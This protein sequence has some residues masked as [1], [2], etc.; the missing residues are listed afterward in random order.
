MIPSSPNERLAAVARDLSRECARRRPQL[1]KV[2]CKQALS[3]GLF[4][5]AS[6]GDRPKL[7]LV[8]SGGARAGDAAA[9]M[10]C[11]HGLAKRL[12]FVICAALAQV[13]GIVTGKA[14]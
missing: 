1:R 10:S 7:S 3:I 4:A 6:A 2:C 8:R 5:Y 14:V 12:S 11:V 13:C 9:H